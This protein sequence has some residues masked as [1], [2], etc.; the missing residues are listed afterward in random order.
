MEGYSGERIIIVGGGASGVLLAC[1]LLRERRCGPSV[2]LIE[3]R[4]EIGK[5]IAFSTVHPDHLMNVRAA[6]MSAFPDDPGHF[7]R[8]VV[9]NAGIDSRTC[10]DPFCFVPRR[11]YGRYIGSLIEVHT[12]AIAGQPR[13]DIVKG[14]ACSI[15]IIPEGVCVRLSDGSSQYGDVAVLATG[16]ETPGYLDHWLCA[17]PWASP[18]EAKIEPDASVLVLGTGLTMVDHVLALVG[19]GHTGP[20]T[21][22][23]RRGLLPQV[24]RHVEEL[25]IHKSDVP[26]GMGARHFWHWLRSM[27]AEEQ[28]RGNDWRAVVDGLRPHTQEIWWKFSTSAK[29]RFVEHARAWWDVHRH[30]MAPEVAERLNAIMASGQLTVAPARVISVEEH[31]FGVKLVYHRRGQSKPLSLI[32]QKIVDCRGIMTDPVNSQNVLVQSM[33]RDGLAR[34]D[35]LRLGLDVTWECEILDANGQSS[36]RLYAV[37]PITRGA[38]WETI[39]VPDIRVQCAKLARR[40]RQRLGAVPA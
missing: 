9:V 7:W 15:A 3:R 34:P 23:S 28:L 18:A 40:L 27:I 26:F 6:N 2:T 8:W 31:A 33:L 24:H 19:A 16:H 25:P 36:Q 11:L 17:N 30:R 5:G 20:I 21:A 12:N 14:E 38:F 35:P 37:G 13:L 22:F 4:S 29:R 1:Q 39:A 32:V 10:A